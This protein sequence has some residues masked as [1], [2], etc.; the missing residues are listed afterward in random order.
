MKNKYY[1]TQ[2]SSLNWEETLEK[3]KEEENKLAKYLKEKVGFRDVI[4]TGDAQ[5]SIHGLKIPDLYGTHKN[6]ITYYIE[7]KHKNRRMKY[8]D[9]GVDEDLLKNY[10]KVQ[11]EFNIRVILI[12][13][14]NDKE[15]KSDFPDVESYFK[16]ELGECTYYGHFL[17]YLVD[18]TPTNP[19]NR[20][21]NYKWIQCFPLSIMVKIPDLFRDRQTE[22][23]TSVIK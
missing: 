10:L 9:N 12:F 4:R 2:W 7:L 22:L 18:S 6:G 3:T 17:D 15:W 5:K 1:N 13:I 14:D 21:F 23:N 16:D 19:K 8:N 20:I 11:E